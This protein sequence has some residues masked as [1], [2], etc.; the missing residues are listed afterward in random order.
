MQQQSSQTSPLPF[1]LFPSSPFPSPSLLSLSLLSPPLTSPLLDVSVDIEV[2]EEDDEGS[3]IAYKCEVHPLWEV[4]VDV[5]RVERMDDG[6]TEL[7]LLIERLERE[8][9]R[10]GEMN[11]I[12]F[13]CKCPH[14]RTVLVPT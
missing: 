8:R 4:A 7:Q 1:L 9:E 5:E 12:T 6:Q 13:R 10:E 11:V 14:M 2:G 3:G